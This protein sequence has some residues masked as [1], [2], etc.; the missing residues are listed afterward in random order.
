MFVPTLCSYFPLAHILLTD[1]VR[2]LKWV[3]IHLRL[4]RLR[5][6]VRQVF[7]TEYVMFFIVNQWTVTHSSVNHNGNMPYNVLT[8]PAVYESPQPP[9]WL[10]LDFSFFGL[11]CLSGSMHYLMQ[12]NVFR[13]ETVLKKRLLDIWTS[14]L[15]TWWRPVCID[16]TQ[17]FQPC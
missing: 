11:K 14:T 7:H 2:P 15:E 9:Y 3:I 1:T 5:T 8:M 16:Q 4:G 12:I 13:G 6:P 17:Q 10:I